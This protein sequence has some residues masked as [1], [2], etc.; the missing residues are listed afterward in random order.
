M[1]RNGCGAVGGT[2]KARNAPVR[3]RTGTGREPAPPRPASVQE[4]PLNVSGSG[5]YAADS[6]RF[7]GL[8]AGVSNKRHPRTFP[9]G[10]EC[11]ARTRLVPVG[12]MTG[13]TLP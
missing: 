6:T 5:A 11:F 9:Q 8:G 10:S 13:R 4:G 12:T 2:N 3:S 1:E 7:N